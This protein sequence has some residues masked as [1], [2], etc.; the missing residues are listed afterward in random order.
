MGVAIIVQGPCVANAK[1]LI[2]TLKNLKTTGTPIGAKHNDAGGV[3][4]WIDPYLEFYVSQKLQGMTNYIY[5]GNAG[6]PVWS[7]TITIHNADSGVTIVCADS[8]IG[9]HDYIGLVEFMP[10]K[11]GNVKLP[12]VVKP[13]VPQWILSNVKEIRDDTK[14]DNSSFIEFDYEC[15]YHKNSSYKIDAPPDDSARP[16][17]MP[18]ADGQS[19]RTDTG[20][21][22]TSTQ[23]NG[24]QTG[25]NWP[26]VI[27]S[28][29]IATFALIVLVYAIYTYCY[30]P[31]RELKSKNKPANKSS[32]PKSGSKESVEKKLND[33]ARSRSIRSNM[34]EASGAKPQGWDRRK[35]AANERNIPKHDKSLSSSSLDSAA[36]NPK[37]IQKFD[38]AKKGGKGANGKR[39][40]NKQHKQKKEYPVE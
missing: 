30:T 33:S 27:A 34:L 22:A 28:C 26:L 19:N 12:F 39:P 24:D 17:A 10:T 13:T 37:N 21:K 11:T 3:G 15:I 36:K 29:V 16:I 23:G 2:A 7:T 4:N 8:D 20:T 5:G 35:K 38:I 40:K 18:G 6:H 25:E 1:C 14:A 31:K 32:L 9:K